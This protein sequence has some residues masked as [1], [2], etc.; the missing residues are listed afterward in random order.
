MTSADLAPL[1]D[2]SGATEAFRTDV[3]AYASRQPATR[4]IAPAG[5]PRV[6]VLRAIS[7]LL[8][9]EP[10][11]A[12][13]R[14]SVHAISGCADYVGSLTVTDAAGDTHRFEFEWNCEWKARE[15][16]YVDGFGFPD[17]IRAAQEFDWRCFQRWVRVASQTPSAV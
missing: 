8:H 15:M 3:L 17:Q 10:Q 4:V 1:L 6:K 13:D 9:A 7:Q 14:V 5:N 12:V 11:L 2:A 16:G